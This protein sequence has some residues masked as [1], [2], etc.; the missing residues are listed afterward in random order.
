GVGEVNQEA[1]NFYNEVIDELIENDIEPINN[2]FHFDMPMRLQEKGGWENREVVEAYVGFAKT[3]FDLFGDRV[4]KWFTHN[5]PLVPVE[6]GYLYQF[7]YPNKVD[8]KKAVQVAYHEALASAKAIKAYHEADQDGE[9]EIIL[10]LT[11]SYA[12]DEGNE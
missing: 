8:M 11:A 6:G 1:V 2:L 10:K 9:I 12:G 7:H 5:E 3:C 4:K